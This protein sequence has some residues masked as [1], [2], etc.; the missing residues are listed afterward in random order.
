[1]ADERL[2]S[3]DGETVLSSPADSETVLSSP[4]GSRAASVSS[5]GA[6]RSRLAA[7]EAVLSPG[8][9]LVDR[10]RIVGLLGR[11]GMGEVYRADDLTLGHAVALKF[12]PQAVIGDQRRLERFLNEVRSARQVAHPN[13][14]RVYDIG[15]ADGHHF[16]TME[17]ID[18]EDFASLLRRIGRLPAD[19]ALE[20]SR[21][22]CAA[23]GAV[24][25]KGLLHCD[26]KPANVMLDGRG[27]VRLTDFGLAAAEGD[28]RGEGE[29]SGTPAYMAPE[30]LA[31]DPP[32]VQS[33][34]Y[35][36]GLVLHELFTGRRVFSADTIDELR[37]RQK[38]FRRG[39]LSSTTVEMDPAV[40]RVIERCLDSDPRNR[41]A[42]AFIVAA[43]LPG[44]DPL[45]A[46][47]AAGETPSPDLVAAAG[48]EGG[49]SARRAWI[50][51]TA[52]ALGLV[53]LFAMRAQTSVLERVPF[54]L[55][56]EVLANK[57]QEMLARLGYQEVPADVA[58]GF[59]WDLDSIQWAQAQGGHDG[60][61][62]P[63]PGQ[64]FGPRFWYRTSPAPLVAQRW[65]GGA[66]RISGRITP[67]DPP[68][69]VPG[70]T[71]VV[72]TPEGRLVEFVA[73]PPELDPES[74]EMSTTPPS[75]E[76]L[77]R[78]TG[79][80][81]DSLTPAESR[82]VPPTW[83]D[84]RTAWTSP[85]AGRGD[86]GL[87]IEGAAY[88]GRPVYLAVTG[89][90][91]RPRSMEPRARTGA[92]WS[93]DIGSLLAFVMLL[94]G[95]LVMARQN[96]KLARAD[97]RGADRLALL[98]ICLF[99]LAW[100][101]GTHHALS[102]ATIGQF[103]MGFSNA[104]FTAALVWLVYLAIE[105][106]VRRRWPHALISWTRLLS[107]RGADPLVGRDVVVG[108]LLGIAGAAIE[109]AS[110][111]LQ[112]AHGVVAPAPAVPAFD[113]LLGVGPALG[114]AML[115]VFQSLF[116][117][118]TLFLALFLFRLVL[119]G[120]WAAPAALI[121]VVSALNGLS[122]TDPVVAAPAAVLMTTL[123]VA[124]LVRFGLVAFAV[125]QYVGLLLT[126]FPM[127]PHL[128]AWHGRSAM[129]ALVIAGAIATYGFRAA[130]A[131][132]SLI[133]EP[134][135]L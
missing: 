103:F 113:T 122:G 132:R 3:A 45:A 83:G 130:L 123:F 16:I 119:R 40:E 77:L 21:Q 58:Y 34:L 107:G 2:S 109:D 28:T 73:V 23:L 75:W 27:K 55:G 124:V 9:I 125:G 17:Y 117:A 102:V 134:H 111:L 116:G 42:S 114:L 100:A 70:M 105:P 10:Y 4:A 94:G 72:L 47:L 92:Q 91:T 76:A 24:H 33:D 71:S 131:G 41:P 133:G 1:M 62:A 97:R 36:L 30:Q 89:P 51:M 14:C 128:G 69:V 110:L 35:A 118:L 112:R 79:L 5:S 49:L 37:D 12:L 135:R 99:T 43:A 48:G 121:A 104:L 98:V 52:L 115:T 57:A 25:D 7:D 95:A 126:I 82:W 85:L 59:A 8:T 53:A 13:V 56:P 63:A 22:L 81:A 101:V 67:L 32:S 88:R 78:E 11:G 61:A 66:E 129:L 44:G 90:W 106:H 68:R 65:V 60:W 84:V 120:R 50:A 26:L 15:T 87:R 54:G 38:R 74:A 29:I 6:L 80:A 39:D 93:Q 108:L 96:L 127:T 18:G 64:P 46:A 20:L 86:E 31:G 19:K